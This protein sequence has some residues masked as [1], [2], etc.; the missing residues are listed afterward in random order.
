[1]RGERTQAEDALAAEFLP[2]TAILGLAQDTSADVYY[3]LVGLPAHAFY[4]VV[5]ASYV[6]V[7]F[8]FGVMYFF[9]ESCI[10]EVGA[11]WC[12]CVRVLC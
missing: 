10:T 9:S 12:V 11:L 6:A 5:V 3:Q 2:R 1:M 8:V 7:V 4:P